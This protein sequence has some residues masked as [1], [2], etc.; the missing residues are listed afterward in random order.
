MPPQDRT[1]ETKPLAKPVDVCR[2]SAHEMIS[3]AATCVA[4]CLLLCVSDCSSQELGNSYICV[5]QRKKQ[6]HVMLG[7]WFTSKCTVSIA[8]TSKRIYT[9]AQIL[10]RGS[11]LQHCK[12]LLH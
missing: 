2:A 6:A 5:L 3:K 7:K 12:C 10:R 11:A 9:H 8:R 4:V 1:I